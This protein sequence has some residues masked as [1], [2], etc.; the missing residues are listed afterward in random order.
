MT[1]S[2]PAPRAPPRGGEAAGGARGRISILWV[3]WATYGSF[4][5][6][7]TNISSALPG[8]EQEFGFSKADLGWVLASFKIAYA[9][10]QLINGQLAERVSPRLL[11]AAGM[12]GSAALS[13]AFGLGVGVWFWLFVWAMNGY[14]QALG[15]TPVMRV[16]HA[17]IPPAN[18][19]VEIGIVGTSYQVT[20][21]VTFVLAGTAADVLGW[22]GAMWVPAILFA[23]A[24]V[25]TLVFLREA[26]ARDAD[27]AG[28][29]AARAPRTAAMP[30][31]ETM[32]AT[33]G[34]P[35]LWLVA[36]SLGLLNATRYGFLDWGLSHV[37]E[38]QPSGVQAAALK[39]AVLPLGGIVGA[40]LSGWASD[41]F[42]SGRR[43]PIVFV[44]LVALAAL[45]VGYQAA[46]SAGPA[47]VVIALVLVG[48]AI[49]GAQVLLVGTFP[50]DLARPG[51]AAASVGFVNCMGYLGA[52]AGDVATGALVDAHGWKT[53]VYAWAA[54]A[55]GAAL[56][57]LPLWNRRAT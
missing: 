46:A 27:G 12:F 17:W 24:G 2:A 15:W 26:P 7:R 6:C 51:T 18:R 35:A 54:Y 55:L 1:A 33:F 40:L 14:A 22:R 19:G 38:M 20:A 31:R 43:A 56:L 34:N 23:A 3:L 8:I 25:N 47:A 13:V 39:Y 53:A 37:K 30:L 5:F 28:E 41:R 36:L 21:A 42:A 16:A 9:A 49:F 11:L 52:A 32:A 10:G 57:L 45:T 50:V 48:A 4:Y 44:L 29:A